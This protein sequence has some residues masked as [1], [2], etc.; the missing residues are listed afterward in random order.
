MR[1]VLFALSL[2]YAGALLASSTQVPL[3]EESDNSGPPVKMDIPKK[4]QT[5]LLQE[6]VTDKGQRAELV[7]PDVGE[8]YAIIPIPEEHPDP[9]DDSGER[10]T[11]SEWQLLT[12]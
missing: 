3:G 7:T 2:C 11:D 5:P 9:L 12:W 1:Y 10:N 4:K 6:F 8:Q